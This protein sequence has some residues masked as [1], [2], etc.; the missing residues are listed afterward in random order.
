MACIAFMALILGSVFLLRGR[1]QFNLQHGASMADENWSAFV[2]M[3]SACNPAILLYRRGWHF[4]KSFSACHA[5]YNRRNYDATVYSD[6]TLWILKH[7]FT[8]CSA[9]VILR[10]GQ[11]VQARDLSVGSFLLLF[12]AVEG[13]GSDLHSIAV[14]INEMVTGSAAVRKIASVLNSETRRL[15][16]CLQQRGSA[17]HSH[18]RPSNDLVIQL[19]HVC[20]TY[21]L[22]ASRTAY[23]VPCLNLSIT[24][25]QTVCFPTESCE[26]GINTLFKL[27]SGY[28][29]PTEGYLRLPDRWRTVYVPVTPILF[30]GTLMYNLMFSD[31]ARSR[32]PS[33]VW[34]VCRALGMSS[35]LLGN[36]DFDVGSHGYYLKFSDR[37]IVSIVRALL[38]DV[39][40]LL[41]SSALDVLGE[42]CAIKVLRYLRQ[43]TQQQGLPDELLPNSLRHVKTV[44]FT[45]KFA[46]LQR[47]AEQVVSLPRPQEA[48]VVGD[49][50]L[51]KQLVPCEPASVE[52]DIG[53]AEPAAPCE[54]DLAHGSGPEE[55]AGSDRAALSG[56]GGGDGGGGEEKESGTC[57]AAVPADGSGSEK[58]AGASGEAAIGGDSGS[59]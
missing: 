49:G 48:A 53:S 8:L 7:V 13:F 42:S 25:G 46:L 1:T 34:D 55:H 47:Q 35:S 9:V 30:D 52:G 6:N 18:H 12:T 56:S 57:E 4:T 26:F 40:L 27:I 50:E 10:A 3:C 16:R 41:I 19:K 2:T 54:A 20:F 11:L 23:A 58:H 5:D 51:E 43:Y 32:D 28:L 29:L 39:D 24:P 17:G 38:H 15:E 33:A 22:K 31:R 21:T 36:D 37:V 14:I 59:E 44:F 45:S